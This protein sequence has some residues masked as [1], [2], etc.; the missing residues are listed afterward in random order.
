MRGAAAG[1]R[2][3]MVLDARA[4]LRRR[5]LAADDGRGG[6]LIAERKALREDPPG[7]HADEI[8]AHV[9]A[10]LRAPRRVPGGLGVARPGAVAP[11]ALVRARGVARADGAPLGPVAGDPPRPAP[12]RERRRQLPAEVDDIAQAGV[13]PKSRRRVIEVSRIAGEEDVARPV[14]LRDDVA[15]RP[16]ADGQDLV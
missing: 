3:R 1:Q 4:R 8:L 13:E 2:G 5:T 12:A 14:P 15:G 10:G 7:L 6:I 11:V 9:A 16:A